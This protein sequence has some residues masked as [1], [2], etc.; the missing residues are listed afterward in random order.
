VSGTIMQPNYRWLLYTLALAGFAADQASKYAV[1]AWLR[2]EPEYRHV[3]A[4]GV[5]DLVAQRKSASELHVNQG[6]LFGLGQTAEGTANGLFAIISLAA[7]AVI[8]FWSTLKST[9]R[10]R[11]LCVALGLIF[12]GTLGNLYDRVFFGGVRDFLHWYYAVNWPVFNF[13]DCCLVCGAGLLLLQAF[14]PQS[15]PEAQPQEGH[16]VGATPFAGAAS[17]A[18]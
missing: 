11:M 2:T 18:K 15:A 16:V 9:A 8:V 7:A 4:P 13:A 14:R 3:V 5:F 1:F 17:D 12:A 6:A 10:D